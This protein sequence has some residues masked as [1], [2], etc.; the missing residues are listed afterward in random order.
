MT[1]EFEKLYEELGQESDRAVATLAV[2]LL[3]ELLSRLLCGYLIQDE[4]VVNSLIEG[5]GSLA[6]FAAKIDMCYVLG[7]I[8][9]AERH[10]L[11]LIRKIRNEFAHNL[12]TASFKTAP[13]EMRCK[14]LAILNRTNIDDPRTLYVGAAMLLTFKLRDRNATQQHRKIYPDDILA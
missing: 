8:N 13:I 5:N 14:E 3:D 12:W 6:T 9:K 11:H 10:D 7:L 1:S 4:Q 2:A